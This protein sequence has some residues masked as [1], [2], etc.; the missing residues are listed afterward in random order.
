[1]LGLGKGDVCVCVCVCVCV[2][3][4]V[5]CAWVLLGMLTCGNE[6]TKGIK[7]SSKPWRYNQRR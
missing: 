4:V 7:S 3:V 5:V 1:M 6:I 2:A